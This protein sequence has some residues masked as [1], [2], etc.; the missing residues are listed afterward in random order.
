[1]SFNL[2]ECSELEAKLKN[3]GDQRILR[4]GFFGKPL[5]TTYSVTTTT[6]KPATTITTYSCCILKHKQGQTE[7]LEEERNTDV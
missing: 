5:K 3:G 1:M 4:R 2:V 6:T 7:D